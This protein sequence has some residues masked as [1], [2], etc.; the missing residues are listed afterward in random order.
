MIFAASATERSL[1]GSAWPL[2]LWSAALTSSRTI[3]RKSETV[4]VTS[5]ESAVMPIALLDSQ[6]ANYSQRSQKAVADIELFHVH[7]IRSQVFGYIA[8]ASLALLIM[9]LKFL[10]C[11]GRRDPDD[12]CCFGHLALGL[13]LSFAHDFLCPSILP[14]S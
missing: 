8:N 14:A 5:I 4:S 6:L 9:P 2:P 1:S 3:S 7:L 12:P 11:T 10:F 13:L